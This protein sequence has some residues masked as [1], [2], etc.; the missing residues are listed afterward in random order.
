M[1]RSKRR[2]RP[3]SQTRSASVYKR[4]LLFTLRLR[5][6]K[7][8]PPSTHE[9]EETL[10]SRPGRLVE[11]GG[12]IAVWRQK[13]VNYMP[14]DD[15]SAETKRILAQ[16]AAYICSNPDCRNNTIGPHS[17][18]AKSLDRIPYLRRCSGRAAL[19]S[20]SNDRRAT[21]HCKRSL[22]LRNM[23]PARR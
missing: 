18:P 6:P 23:Q 5:S 22:P 20:K 4:S 1:R 21:K 13:L 9:T 2:V 3:K 15:F 7:L 17:D 8:I 14:R 19:W 10:R 12:L 11:T 16:R